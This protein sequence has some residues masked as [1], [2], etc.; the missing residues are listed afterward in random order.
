MKRPRGFTGHTSNKVINYLREQNAKGKCCSP[1]EIKRA[2]HANS[3]AITNL[4]KFLSDL[5][6]V[7]IHKTNLHSFVTLKNTDEAEQ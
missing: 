7:K 6:I 1:N 4:L 2:T 5:N 3:E